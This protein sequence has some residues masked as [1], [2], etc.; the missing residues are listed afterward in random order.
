MIK[1]E[2]IDDYDYWLPKELLAQRPEPFKE[3]RLLVY[4]KTKKEIKHQMFEDIIDYLNPGDVVVVNKTKVFPAKLIGKKETGGKIEILLTSKIN[5]KEWQCIIKGKTT[6]N[7]KV[8]LP[9]NQCV[10][11]EKKPEEYK[12][13]VMFNK[14]ITPKY[15][16]E[17][18]K[19]P[20]P[21]YIKTD[22]PL[23]KYQT[24]F[25][26]ET[27]SI[28]SPTAGLHFSDELVK[29]IKDKGVDFAEVCL[30]VGLGTFVPVKEQ[31]FKKH[32]MHYETYCVDKHNADIIN[33]RKGNLFI[34]GTTT[35]RTLETVT[36]EEGIVIPGK[37]KTNLFIYPG[38]KFKT[39]FKGFITNFHLP[40]TT[41]LLLVAAVIGRKELFK[42]YSEA[43]KKRYRF[44][45]FGDA[46]MILR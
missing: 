29:R 3:H 32:Q 44:Y 35:M 15:L 5:G 11:T 39:K 45:S 30:H 10:I 19:T 36:N 12:F 33:K 7:T 20:L 38:Y 9:E 21:P 24:I 31:D 16:E 26:R 4:N 18:G 2:T 8:I 34:V 43:I 40:K 23:D 37:G 46:M 1:M 25:A 13:V 41:L 17:Y 42:V 27:G 22:A 14:P 28:A 6:V